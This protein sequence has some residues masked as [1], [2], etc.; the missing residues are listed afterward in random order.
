MK[1]RYPS[2]ANPE[3]IDKSIDQATK[4]RLQ[5]ERGKLSY[6]FHARG[7]PIDEGDERHHLFHDGRELMT[8]WKS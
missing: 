6:W 2:L 8:Y 4:S 1:E 7:W 3:T 5:G